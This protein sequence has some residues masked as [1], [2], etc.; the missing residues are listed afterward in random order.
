[1]VRGDDPINRIHAR[2]VFRDSEQIQRQPTVYWAECSCQRCPAQHDG[3]QRQGRA[4]DSA[5]AACIPCLSR[6]F[7]NGTPRNRWRQWFA[8]SQKSAF[9]EGLRLAGNKRTRP[10][11]GSISSRA[12][13][14]A[15][16]CRVIRRSPVLRTD[17]KDAALP[18]TARLRWPRSFMREDQAT[19]SFTTGCS[20]RSFPFGAATALRRHRPVE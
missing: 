11:I 1:M 13:T 4:D 17:D 5:A 6:P 3:W 18:W 15:E 10:S 14:R 8:E 9:H 12:Q 19:P 7:G 2:I 16:P 20:A